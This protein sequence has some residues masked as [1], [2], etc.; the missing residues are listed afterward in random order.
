MSYTLL[1][2]VSQEMEVLKEDNRTTITALKLPLPVELFCC[3]FDTSKEDSK[4]PKSRQI[5]EAGSM[6][7]LLLLPLLLPPLLLL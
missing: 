3:A 5:A 1:P 7:R 2:A 4:A 6:L